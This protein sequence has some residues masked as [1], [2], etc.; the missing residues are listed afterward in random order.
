MHSKPYRFSALDALQWYYK[1]KQFHFNGVICMLEMLA[2]AYAEWLSVLN[3]LK[4]DAVLG[5]CTHELMTLSAAFKFSM[6]YWPS[7]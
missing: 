5:E 1:S 4:V 2:C 6:L 7:F 3:K